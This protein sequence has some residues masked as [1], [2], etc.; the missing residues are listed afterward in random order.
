MGIMS[1]HHQAIQLTN[2]L[3][4]G[5][6]PKQDLG[7][8]YKQAKQM[9]GF[10][11]INFSA[12]EK[13]SST[14][15]FR[16]VHDAA[17]ALVMQCQDIDDI[18][19]STAPTVSDKNPPLDQSAK[20]SQVLYVRIMKG[21]QPES[22]K[23]IVELLEG[24]ESF[25]HTKTFGKI[26]F[27]SNA[28]AAKAAERLWTETNIYSY[29]HHHKPDVDS[30][31]DSSTAGGSG[32]GGGRDGGSGDGKVEEGKTVHIQS[33]D[34]D[35]DGLYR[36]F[37]ELAGAS[38]IGYHKGYI[39]ICFDKHSQ[40]KSAVVRINNCTKMK[41]RIV[42]FEYSPHFTPGSIGTP[43]K[44]VRMN[45]ITSTPTESEIRNVFMT[46][47]GFLKLSYTSKKCWATFSTVEAATDCVEHFNTHTNIKVV[48]CDK[49]K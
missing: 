14:I 18:G 4:V 7:D 27:T 33:L 39:F 25:F 46:R 37:L 40:A 16:S 19:F 12:T 23:K 15:H 42:E 41:A 20:P 29:F 49:T 35:F 34:R 24:F 3:R 31:A 48:F 22:L 9:P 43:V 1:K 30:S 2:C 26:Y 6:S 45:F 44:T 8:L 47:P 17:L 5:S 28:L 10:V 11:R 36:L 13:S 32:C 38:R 21:M